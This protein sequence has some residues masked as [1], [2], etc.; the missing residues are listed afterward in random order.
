MKLFASMVVLFFLAIPGLAQN[1]KGDRPEV[2]GTRQNRFQGKPGK[3][4]KGKQ[5]YNRVTPNRYSL[6]NSARSFKRPRKPSSGNKKIFSQKGGFINNASRT[7]KDKQQQWRAVSTSRVVVRSRSGKTKN[8]YPQKGRYVNNSSGRP[9]EARKP[10]SNNRTL[11]RLKKL[12]RSQKTKPPRKDD[13]VIPRSASGSFIRNKTINTNARF[14][15]VRRKGEKA[16]TTDLAGKP[17]RTKNFRTP[18]REV[19]EPTFH[20]YKGRK[21]VGDRAYK[22]PA[23]GKY[24]SSTRAGQHAWKGDITG[25]KIRGRNY[26]SKVPSGVGEPT[27]GHQRINGSSGD[28]VYKGIVP[29]KGYKSKSGKTKAGLFPNPVRTPGIGANGIGYSGR[30]K[31]QRPLKGG[32]SRS[33]RFWNNKGYAI[34]PKSP[35]I[36]ADRVG[37]FQG[38]IKGGRPIK[39]GGSRSGRLWNNKGYAIQPKTPGI[40]AD[41]VGTFQGNIKGGKP[42]KGGGSRSGKTWNNKGYAIQ[43]KTPGIGADRIGTFQGNIKGG[44]P[45]KGGGSRSGKTWNNKGYAI[46]PKTPGI[47]AD[48]IGTFQGN[49]KTNRQAKGGGSRSGQLWNNKRTPIAVRTP[50]PDAAKA[51]G[52][53]GKIRRFELTPGYNNQGDEFTGFIKTRKPLKGGGS[54]SGKVWNN[55]NAAIERKTPGIGANKIGTFQGNIKGSRPIKGGGSVSGKVWNNKTTPI[56]VKTPPSSAQKAGTYQGNK[57]LFELTPGFNNQGEEFTGYIKLPKY[58]KKAYK[59]NPN[60]AEESILKRRPNKTTYKVDNLQVKVERRKYV[61]N[62][63]LPEEATKKLKPTAATNAVAN[64]Q[65]RVERRK[66]VVNKNLPEVASKKLKPTDATNA[67]G[68]LQVKVKQY[69]YVHNGSSSKEALNVREPGKAFAKSTDYQG[70]IKMKKFELAK[71]FSERNRELHPDA[72]FVKLNKNNVK[73]ERSFLTNV[74]LWWARSFRKSETQPDHLKEKQHKPRYDKGESGMW[75][76]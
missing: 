23:S 51:G 17:L 14:W 61:T 15:N 46:Q 9:Q 13:Q 1:T 49:I 69:H 50:S 68:N 35:G 8:V 16:V 70:N 64:L 57:Y 40:G 25:R 67:V 19:L 33:G 48:R 62:K 22:G 26:S 66:Y 20:P 52:F 47:G 74:K 42:L 41:R 58:F 31:G 7:P 36:G 29:G 24:V 2:S 59:K 27:M 34:Q 56:P 76:E 73:E 21:R 65:V 60:A 55:K 63:D 32:G 12:Q 53:P 11:K 44:K 5:S 39:G 4:Q 38:N 28:R 72:K 45:L 71:L 37:T 30:L 18:P 75:N 10:V 6:A 54:V 43:P 3:N